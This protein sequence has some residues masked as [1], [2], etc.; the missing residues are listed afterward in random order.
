MFD[1]L[2]EKCSQRLIALAL[3]ED[4]DG[5]GDI[6]SAATIPGHHQS[7]ANFVTRSAGVLAGMQAAQMVFQ[8]IDPA[9]TFAIVRN[10]G[11]FVGKDKVIARVEGSTRAILTAERTA[12]NFL[13]HLSGIATLTKRYVDA[14]AGADPGRFP[15][16][17]ATRKT[18]PGWRA[19]A[20]YAVQ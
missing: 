11:E 16:I 10:D 8:A 2:E 7:K 12:L 19:L 17:L 15:Q 4:L 9:T 1:P 5:A 3:Q 6:T 20:K 14:V 13:Q 18:I